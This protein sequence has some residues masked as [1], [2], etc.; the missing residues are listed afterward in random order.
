MTAASSV[1]G[2]FTALTGVAVAT[3][4][5]GLPI[6]VDGTAY[7]APRTFLWA[8]G[9][10]HTVAVNSPLSGPV[11]TRYVWSNWTDGGA[12]SHTVV[13]P[14]SAATETA[15]FIT[16][17]LLTLGTS[18]P[19]AGTLTPNPA[20]P[21]GD[22]YY[23]SGTAVQVTASANSTYQFANFSG[24]LTGSTNPQTVNMTAASAVT[25]NFSVGYRHPATSRRGAAS[26][27][28]S[29]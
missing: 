25:G 3:N 4:P 5:A 1:T 19:A 6:S 23:T 11:G 27:S 10:N 24:A 12:L 9:S 16:Q 15:S 18:P 29:G 7:T 26:G 2:N 28:G 21:G 13:A 8:P 22:G 14:A 20:S 17:Y